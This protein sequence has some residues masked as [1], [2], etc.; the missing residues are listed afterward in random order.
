M[1]AYNL[2][3]A[4][5]SL[6]RNPVLTAVIIGGIALGI[7]IST[8]FTTIR[9]M[10]TRDPLPGK[11][12][13]I[14]YV[15]LDNWDK[16]Q[17]Y[18]KSAGGGNAYDVPPQITYKDASALVR[19][20]I[21]VHQFLSYISG[22]V[23]FPDRSVSRPYTDRIRFTQSDFFL[24]FDVP[25]RYGH[26]WDRRA[27]AAGEQV[28]VIDDATNQKLFGGGNSVGKTVRIKDRSFTVVGVLAPWRPFIRV[29][30]LINNWSAAPEGIYL[31]FAVG[32][33]MEA[34]PSG[35]TDVPRWAPPFGQDFAA[36]LR[37]ELDYVQLWAEL[38]SPADRA[39]Y[40]RFID[41]YVRQQ[42]ALGRFPRPVND[43]VLSLR[44]LLTDMNVMRPSVTAMAVISIL[45]L[46]IC[47]LNLTGLVL[48]KFL[49]RV[50]E[51]S[52]RRALGASRA[53]VFLQHILECEL[54]GIAGGAIGMILSSGIV[55]F[56]GKLITDTTV[57]SL[58]L[59]MI[60]SAVFLSL[61]AGFVA[62][63]Y[64][65]W[66]ICNTQPAVQLKI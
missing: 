61:V 41:D 17:A 16:D 13:R 59:E 15:R 47:S 22:L 18:P 53:D 51:V 5:R 60:A 19:S 6:R 38:R 7:C 29:Y 42:K 44:E 10:F 28:A 27:D 54:V 23:V 26:P 39:A 50:P 48:G 40:Q 25:F 62:G 36:A 43:P 32:T 64:P 35:E 46:V 21:P 3:I 63:L 9:H 1:L 4:A 20:T 11:S 12:A 37:S 8:T 65:A 31:P 14:V 24:M 45:F 55:R 33:R 34:R 2:R 57:I 52:V 58:D 30:D 56:I 66:R 49:A